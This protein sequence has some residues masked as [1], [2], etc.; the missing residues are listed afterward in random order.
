M[1]ILLW[2]GMGLVALL[3]LAALGL[4]VAGSQMPR[5]HR[6][7]TSLILRANRATVWAALTD[8]ASM[9]S[10]WPAVKSIHVT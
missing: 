10:W 1:K 8:Y 7:Q 6:A 2:V 5:E 3:V 4:Y 9:P